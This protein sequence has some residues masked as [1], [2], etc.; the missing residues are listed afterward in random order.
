MM[1][2]WTTEMARA[3][4]EC[5]VRVAV[6]R[7]AVRGPARVAHA[8]GAGQLDAVE[9]LLQVGELAGLA[10]DGEPAAGVDDRDTGRVVAPVLHPP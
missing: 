9:L 8:G 5:G 1:P 10:F 2:L 3:Q 7:R 4:S 6:G